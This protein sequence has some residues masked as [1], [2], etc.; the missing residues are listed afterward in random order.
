MK[1]ILKLLLIYLLLTS[2]AMP[3]YGLRPQ[4]VVRSGETEFI[5]SLLL[6]EQPIAPRV[7][8]NP[9][10]SHL[11]KLI[12]PHLMPI[13][14]NIGSHVS[15]LFSCGYTGS[16]PRASDYIIKRSRSEDGTFD[17]LEE[18]YGVARDLA[19]D[20]CAPFFFLQDFEYID[21]DGKIQKEEEVMVQIRLQ[22]MLTFYSGASSIISATQKREA[23]DGVN[24]I[25]HV[26]DKVVSE[27]RDGEYHEGATP[28]DI[29][30]TNQWLTMAEELIEEY[31]DYRV[32]CWR[33]GI[34]DGDEA[35]Y[36]TGVEITKDGGPEYESLKRRVKAYDMH[37]WKRIP[38]TPEE[39]EYTAE[40]AG[41][42]MMLEDHDAFKRY[43]QRLLTEQ[44][45]RDAIIIGQFFENN[46]LREKLRDSFKRQADQRL[47]IENMEKVR[48]KTVQERQSRAVPM[49][50][51]HEY[52][53]MVRGIFSPEFISEADIAYYLNLESIGIEGS[54]YFALGNAK[55]DKVL[56]F[57]RCSDEVSE[58][59]EGEYSQY[60]QEPIKLIQD[61]GRD[62]VVRTAVIRNTVVSNV[63]SKQV[64]IGEAVGQDLVSD[65]FHDRLEKLVKRGEKESAKR[66]LEEFVFLQVEMWRRGF[67]DPDV[68]PYDYGVIGK[69]GSE[70]VICYDFSDLKEIPFEIGTQDLSALERAISTIRAYLP[71]FEMFI[72]DVDSSVS[73]E[74]TTELIA[75][76]EKFLD[77]EITIE[78]LLENIPKNPEEL[79]K[80]IDG[81]QMFR[82]IFEERDF[83]KSVLRSFSKGSKRAPYYHDTLSDWR[84]KVIAEKAYE[85]I[86]GAGIGSRASI[87]H[88]AWNRGAVKAVSKWVRQNICYGMGN[89]AYWDAKA[90][91]TLLAKS[92]NDF[93]MTNLQ[94][95]LLRA[96]GI[97]C[98]Y[99]VAQR[100]K[101]HLEGRVPQW[102]YESL[103]YA[104]EYVYAEVFID[105]E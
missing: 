12:K 28:E 44:I 50:I 82:T 98:K 89:G 84:E 17:L 45:E 13:A 8:I 78:N 96:L 94:I 88:T 97:P 31:M 76:L 75:Y 5:D 104:S 87:G 51:P 20:L 39:L 71:W 27:M 67:Y 33:R 65:Y 83:K 68:G 6:S 36:D 11:L 103:D 77:R 92:G 2:I 30:L 42:G 3:S 74:L 99:V 70:R 49:R 63:D 73:G 58:W 55:S 35:F 10:N 19:G 46:F 22:P 29:E 80:R 14:K 102:Y 32:E 66:L 25:F 53:D 40:H 93:N 85:I 95:S 34:F 64:N 90:T 4:A 52:A 1:N 56:K 23:A 72:G 86:D 37:G 57:L 81:C 7:R 21:E 60:L 79:A 91:D 48:P 9:P 101:D 59:G 18:G 61:R 41:E 62:L 69:E 43:Y 47:T 100:R 15:V 24:S 54:H 105:D 38:L 26:L 16:Y